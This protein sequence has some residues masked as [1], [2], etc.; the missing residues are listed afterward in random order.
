MASRDTCVSL[1]AADEGRLAV[2]LRS[3]CRAVIV[4]MLMACS[5]AVAM[6]HQ[7]PAARP[8]GTLPDGRQAT[9]YTLAVR[10]GWQATIT[11]YGGIVTSLLV[12]QPDG[13]SVD[14]VLGF[15]TLDGYLAGH[16]YFGAICGRVGNRIA[17]GHFMLDDRPFTL[18]RNNGENHLHGGLVGFD[19]QLW[20]ATPLV[21]DVGPAVDLE[22]IS[23]DGDEGYP[24]R[25]TAHVRYTLTP[26]GELWVEME[27]VTTA[28]TIVNLVHHSYWNLAGQAAGRID[29]HILAARASRY[30]PLDGGGIPTGRLVD[31]AGTPFDF[32]SRPVRLGDAIAASTPSPEGAAQGGVDH[33][34]V[35]DGWKPD[36]ALRSAVTLADPASGRSLEILTDQPGVQ[37]YT[38]NYLDG[39]L[40]G[41]Q[42]AV[43]GQH[44]AVCLET[45]L[46]PDA[47]HH[48][49]WPSTR[50][51]PGQTYRHVMVHRFRGPD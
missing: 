37:V 13:D 32:R 21:S 23:P 7:P 28:S 27:A 29:D 51:E 8:F 3:C 40:T 1:S 43:Y 22:L 16:P 4:I 30:L 10:G 44:A 42:G 50:L 47:V 36:G 11:D 20:K 14:V 35:I 12:P 26:D 19:K 2:G 31:V 48:P 18:A 25:L 6:D 34:L 24:G 33:C 39:S 49:D 17:G 15:D 45:E 41:K 46:F 9:L 38:G 5:G